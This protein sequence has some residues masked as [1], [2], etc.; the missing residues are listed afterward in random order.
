MSTKR[1]RLSRR[2]RLSL[3]CAAVTGLAQGLARALIDAIACR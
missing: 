2:E 3:L 1:H